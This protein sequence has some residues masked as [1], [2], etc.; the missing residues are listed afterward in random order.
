[1]HAAR[2]SGSTRCLVVARPLGAAQGLIICGGGLGLLRRLR[3]CAPIGVIAVIG[4]SR[5]PSDPAPAGR[6]VG[7]AQLCGKGVALGDSCVA[8]GDNCVTLGGQCV[9]LG[10]QCVALALH[11]VE[12]PRHGDWDAVGE[13]AHVALRLL[14]DASG[15]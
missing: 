1:M 13:P 7:T 10:G 6:V 14:S 12:P 2:D 3:T 5:E 15:V 9:A 11:Y 4:R 8:L